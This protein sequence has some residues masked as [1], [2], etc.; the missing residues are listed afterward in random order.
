[1]VSN[2]NVLEKK[3]NGTKKCLPDQW[4]KIKLGDVIEYTKGF[5]FKSKEYTKN[6]VRIIR[7]S[8]TTANSISDENA[9]YIDLNS[10]SKYSNWKLNE[11]DIIISTVGSKPPMYDSLVGKAIR[12]SKKYEGSLLNQNAA[13]FRSNV[14]NNR[15]IYENLRTK[16]YIKHIEKIFRGNANQASITIKELL[17]FEFIVPKSGNEQK[18]IATALSNIDD[19][20]L[21]IEKLINKKKLIKEGAMDELLTGKRRL[22]GFSEEWIKVKIEE[23]GVFIS[24]NGF[25]SKYQGKTNGQYPF[26]K[27]SDMNNPG[28]EIYM[29]TA[30]NYIGDCERKVIGALVLDKNSIVFAKIGAAIFLERKRILKINSCI[31]NNMMGFTPYYDKCSYKY[32][33]MIFCKMEFGK[34]A[35]TSALP[36]LN[37][38][39]IGE[40]EILIPGDINEQEAIATILSDMDNE[41]EKL[42]KKLDKYKNI[43]SGMMEE[44]LTGKRRLV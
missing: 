33:Y 10:A 22:D 2:N 25:P 8:D 35:N 26:F 13:I 39:D 5:A 40:Q 30:N 7:V 15:L 34:L 24:G 42:E 43:K 9:I 18:A 44:L 1:M 6:G 17:E 29:R 37:R 14:I 3:Y 27:V 4:I 38:N 12:I 19:L 36:S 32:I 20:I 31:D 28:N 11:D 21:S 41:I 16:N 23:L